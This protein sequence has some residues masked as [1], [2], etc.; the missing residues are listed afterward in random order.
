MIRATAPGKV[1]V[2]G[3]YAV[4]AGAPAVAMAV[5]A[6]ATATIAGGRRSAHTVT[7]PGHLDAPRSFRS[8]GG[9]VAWTDAVAGGTLPLFERVWQSFRLGD[10]APLDITLDTT[11]FV[12]P[13]TGTKYGFGS[14]ASAALALSLA[15]SKLAP[16]DA[17]AQA[18]RAHD[19][20]QGGHGSGVDIAASFHGGLIEYRAA[21]SGVRRLAW[22]SGLHMKL[23]FS[24]IAS[25]T[26]ERIARLQGA[27][28]KSNSMTRLCDVAESL[29]AGWR[30]ADVAG[31]LAGLR[32]YT[33]ALQAFSD[34]HDLG[35]FDAGH[36]ELV[37][38]AAAGDLLYKPCGAGGGDCGI[39]LGTEPERIAAFCR[40]AGKHGYSTLEYGL[41]VDGAE[42]NIDRNIG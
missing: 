14:S 30:A 20:F 19:E 29:P 32:Q 3:E 25:S 37:S 22:P 9:G 40:Q 27:E 35:I 31:I 21:N 1:V 7:A 23:V 17:L 38:L 11:A 41:C 2:A 13:R 8:N 6:R 24:G 12:H 5:D 42:A 4:L 33:E 28:M 18:R 26:R 16:A 36:G 39:V 34:A 15:L 10:V